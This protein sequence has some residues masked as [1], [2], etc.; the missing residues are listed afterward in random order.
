M[1]TEQIILKNFLQTSV[2]YFNL[3]LHAIMSHFTKLSVKCMSV[4]EFERKLS[5][6]CLLLLLL[7]V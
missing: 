7:V 5:D 3:Y 1:I 4:C 2:A 6:S